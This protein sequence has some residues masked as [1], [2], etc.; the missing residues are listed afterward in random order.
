[1]GL[2]KVTYTSPSTEN[3]MFSIIT[4]RR[5][6]NVPMLEKDRNDQNYAARDKIVGQKTHDVPARFN[7]SVQ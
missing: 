5:K 4:L 6:K 1:M 7:R 2:D 3:E